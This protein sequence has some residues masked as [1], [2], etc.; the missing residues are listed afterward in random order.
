MNSSPV[1]LWSRREWLFATAAL[2]L[3]PKLRATELSGFY[4]RDYS[5][6]L[7][8]YLSSL[9][10]AA[11]EKRNAHLDAL[12]NSDA[13]LGRQRWVRETFWTL[14][15]GEPERTPLSARIT[16]QLERTG[17]RLQ[18]VVYESR[19]RVFVSANLYLPTAGKAPYPGVLFQM[20]HY[21][22]GKA[23]ASYQKCCQGLARL[24]Y[25]VLAFDPM[26]QGERIAYPDASGINT[27]LGSAT[28]EHDVPGKQMLLVGDSASRQQVWDAIRSLDYLAGH[29]LVD[30]QRL[31]STGQSG[32][33]TLTMLL[34]CVDDR[35]SAAAVSSGNTENFA[36]A[37]FDPPGATDDAEQ[38]FIGSGKLGFDRWDLLYPIAPK[39][40]LIEVSAH[41]FFGTYSPRYLDDG[42][43]QYQRLA[44]VY[45][46]LG[47]SEH[48]TW[49]STPLTHGLTYSLRLGIY[50]WFERWL[51]KSE[52]T[53]QEEPLVAPENDSALWVGPTGNVARDFLSLRPF[54][55]VKERAA[56]TRREAA[57]AARSLTAAGTAQPA[58][59]EALP[60]VFPSERLNFTTL[61]TVPLKGA[62]VSAVEVKTNIETTAGAEIWIPAWLFRPD[63]V[64][65]KRPALL[66]LDDRGRNAH[67]HEDDIYHRVARSGRPVYAADIRGIGDT[68]PEA[69]RGNPGYTIPH[70][71]EEEFA[72]ASLILGD[73][74]LAQRVS[75]ILA[76]AQAVKN[77]VS[78]ESGPLALA[79]RGRLTVPALFAFAASQEFGS[80]YLAGGLLSFENLL[81]TEIYHQPLVNFAWDLFRYTDL[82]SL[83]AQS[84]PRRIHLAGTMDASNNPVP[85]DAL[86]SAYSSPNVQFSAEPVWDEIVLGSV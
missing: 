2:A 9:A 75:D 72:W 76:L 71:D 84:A 36:C 60:I 44:R 64:D 70:D 4:Y 22:S 8:E 77:S 73:P 10:R 47:H 74:L 23:Y 31:A 19:P 45:A 25:I 18:K 28:E 61:A 59:T 34:A 56:A 49:R 79:A 82:P 21:Y 15:G 46:V 86:R 14:I 67:A 69:G 80:L 78:P 30:P 5:R 37:R 26:G 20:G 6:C 58:W 57:A 85:Q 13:I 24:G 3:R 33:G 81:E 52:R 17:Y 62:Q 1:N 39:P 7:P 11:Y 48:L 43:E 42:R 38:D 40:L 54:D 35:L 12:T 16:G 66:V 55:L 29:E 53:I 32:G 51:M 83:A 50:N 27:R 68:R 63:Q 41:D 65:S